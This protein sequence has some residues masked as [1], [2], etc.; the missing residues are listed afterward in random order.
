MPSDHHLA[1]VNI[2][3]ARAPLNDPIMEGFVQQLEF[4]N[5]CAERSPGFVWRLQTEDGDAT[6]ITVFDDPELVVNM[7]VWESVGALRSSQ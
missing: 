4:I 1:Q 6:G 3:R 5:A 2:A 7:S